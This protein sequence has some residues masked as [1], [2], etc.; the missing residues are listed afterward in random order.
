M[1]WCFSFFYRKSR[2]AYWKSKIC[3][4]KKIS[5]KL[6]VSKIAFLKKKTL[7]NNFFQNFVQKQSTCSIASK[8]K[9]VMWREQN[10]RSILYLYKIHKKSIKWK[11][12]DTFFY[13]LEMDF[14]F[15]YYFL[16]YFI[17]VRWPG[18]SENGTLLNYKIFEIA[19]DMNLN[20]FLLLK[21]CFDISQNRQ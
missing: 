8:N 18:L 4:A 10:S 11:V 5:I 3:K 17:C 21:L 15:F 20:L 6:N 9:T 1:I 16:F 7:P 2:N 12:M 14:I 19:L 13:I